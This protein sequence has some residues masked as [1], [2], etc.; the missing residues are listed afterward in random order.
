[1]RSGN[2]TEAPIGCTGRRGF[3]FFT[4]ERMRLHDTRERAK[5]ELQRER[6][7]N[8]DRVAKVHDLPDDMPAAFTP[9]Y[10]MRCIANTRSDVA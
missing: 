8:G 3:R 4:F 10:W 9:G 2:P 1:M 7:K 6:V 5:A